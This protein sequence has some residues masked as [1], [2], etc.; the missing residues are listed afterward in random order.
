M[1][2]WGIAWSCLVAAGVS[3]PATRPTVYADR[4]N[5]ID[6]APRSARFVR[7]VIH[8]SSKSEPCIDELEVYGP[9]GETNLALGAR[10]AKPTASSCLPGYA[11]HRIEHLNDGRYGNAHSWIAGSQRDAWAQIELPEPA[12]V[13]RVVFSRD[14][15]GQHGDRVPLDVEVLVSS[16]GRQWETVAEARGA[17]AARRG[18]SGWTDAEAD[19]IDRAAADGDYQRLAFLCERFSFRRIDPTEPTARVLEQM[20]A[21]IERLA[22]KGI[23]VSAEHAAEAALRR[24]YESIL[25]AGLPRHNTEALFLE[26]RR[27]KRRL[28]F[29][30]RDLEPLGR[31]LFVKRH[32]YAPSHNYSDLFDPAGAPGGAVCVL[33]IPR[34]DG[35]FVPERATTTVLFDAGEGVARDPVPELACEN[36]YFAY[37]TTKT[38][39]FH[40]YVVRVDGGDARRLTDGPFHDVFPCPLPD[41]GLA[42]I[43]TR[44]RARFLC[45]R[46]Q[47]Y[48]LFRMDVGGGEPRPLSHAN[49][50]EWTP[51]VARDGRIL[52]MRSEYLDRGADFG[53]TV[54][55]IRPDGAHPELVFGNNTRNCYAGPR[56]VPGS[57]ELVCTLVSHGGDLNGPI[58]LVEPRRG[59]FNPAAVRSLTPDVAPHYHMSWARRRCFRDP[60]PISRDHVLCSHAPDEHFALYV[61]DRWGNREMLHYDPRIGSMGP[62]PLRPALASPVLSKLDAA[63]ETGAEGEFYVVDV[64]RG[65]E[66]AVERGAV[67]WIRVCCE[68]RSELA[69]LPN[70]EYR[71]DHE[72]FRDWYASPTHRVKGPHGWPS[73]VAKA[74]YGLA[75]V[76]RDGSAC[77]RAPAGKV[78]YFQALDENYNELQRMRSVV[79]LQP[80]ERRGCIGCHEDRMLAPS[81]AGVPLAIRRGAEPLEP[82]PWGAGPFSY[83]R[84]VQVVWDAHCTRCHGDDDSR[85]VRLTGTLDA[86][87]VP[88]SYRTLIEQGWVHYFDYTYRREH[89]KASPRSFGTLKSRLW[90]LLDGGHY[91]A[92]LSREDMRRVKCWIDLNCPLWPDYQY[93]LD[94]PGAVVATAGPDAAAAAARQ[95]AAPVAPGPSPE[96]PA[97]AATR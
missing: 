39:Y 57:D 67:R 65:L 94:R 77:F 54:W 70:G 16:D 7:L 80:G 33:E 66:P 6:F 2:A 50:S 59:R 88:A 25:A 90:T 78:L 51:S 14:R 29:R 20:S 19:A 38:D 82:P 46:P 10:G 68:V 13:A 87:R 63:A 22:A 23:D 11:I 8:R 12:Q 79:Q 83:E 96:K 1:I 3:A 17:T 84:V 86:D 24:R 27:A 74:T 71:A 69:R 61:I 34:V 91:D 81:S 32:P 15:D 60:F 47:A 35:S 28:F 85:G 62:V 92:R 58:A 72:P 43:S 73:Y 52:W 89:E 41:G 40:L 37:R 55:A 45:W 36:V 5:T 97:E 18:E 26:A 49:L 56:E 31:I 64:N 4:P 53:H 48:V 42:F 76:E 30:D 95:P 75:R 21:M 93:R 9:E 44:C